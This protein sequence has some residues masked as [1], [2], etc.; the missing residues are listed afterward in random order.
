MTVSSGTHSDNPTYDEGLTTE[1]ADPILET[2]T[3]L[4]TSATPD[5]PT[6]DE[7]LTTEAAD[8]V[9]T[10]PGHQVYGGYDWGM[11]RKSWKGRA[12]GRY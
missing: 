7:G 11:F 1:E 4:V 8:P 2:P 12:E 5:G 6:Y 9:S 10:E 3:T